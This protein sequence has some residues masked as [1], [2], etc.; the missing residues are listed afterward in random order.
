MGGASIENVGVFWWGDA[1]NAMEYWA[2]GL[3]QRLVLLG[4][5]QTALTAAAN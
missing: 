2:N 1:K 4:T 3:D 5:Q